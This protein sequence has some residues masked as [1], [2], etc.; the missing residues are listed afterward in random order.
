MN[1]LVLGL[2]IWT[3]VSVVVMGAIRGFSRG[4]RKDFWK[5]YGEIFEYGTSSYAEFEEGLGCFFTSLGS[6][7]ACPGVGLL[8]LWDW[9]LFPWLAAF[10]RVLYRSQH[11]RRVKKAVSKLSPFE[12]RLY[13]KVEQLE[14]ARKAL[15]NEIEN[16]NDCDES[17]QKALDDKVDQIETTERNLWAKISRL[18]VS[19]IPAHVHMADADRL[20][21]EALSLAETADDPLIL[22]LNRPVSDVL[23]VEE[24]KRAKQELKGE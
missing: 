8:A 9:A 5:G 20:I 2:L 6:I 15:L 11:G 24:Q 17:T 10:G 3:L 18:P 4:Q 12:Q 13:H 21:E 1:P 16:C 7:A 22:E 23:T 14:V 19:K